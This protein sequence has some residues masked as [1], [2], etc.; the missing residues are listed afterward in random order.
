MAIGDGGNDLP[1]LQSVGLGIA[2]GN[3]VPQVSLQSP[4][5]I[6]G[7]LQ[8]A[9]WLTKKALLQAL[10]FAFCNTSASASCCILQQVSL[11][12]NA[13]RYML[14]TKNCGPAGQATAVNCC[15]IRLSLC[16]CLQQQTSQ[17]LTTMT[18]ALQRP[19][20]D[21]FCDGCFRC[22]V[23]H[24]AGFARHDSWSC[25]RCMI[26]VLYAECS[27]C[28]QESDRTQISLCALVSKVVCS[29]HLH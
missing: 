1:L 20:S 18:A 17:L 15:K 8:H 14:S 7:I 16:R 27:S 6:P 2:M 5:C 28:C 29:S 21:S 4:A 3:A 23:M 24:E 13:M 19:L 10:Y 25:C 22:S 9:C 26:I 12:E 11:C